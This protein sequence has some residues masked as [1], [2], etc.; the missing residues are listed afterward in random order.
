MHPSEESDD[1]QTRTFPLRLSRR[2]LVAGSGVALA[3]TGIASIGAATTLALQGTPEA[4][5][6]AQVPPEVP[7]EVDRPAAYFNIHEAATVDALVS[8][9]LPG[10]AD[11]PGAHEAG[12]VFYIDGQLAGTNL[13]YTLK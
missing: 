13:G 8:R 9:I 7:Q 11:D 4:A 1:R 10:T 6:Q 5:P 3:T 2:R 12:V